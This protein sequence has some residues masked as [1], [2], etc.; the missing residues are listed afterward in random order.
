MELLYLSTFYLQYSMH[1]NK[2]Q[3]K[4]TVSE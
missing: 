1:N 3:Y 2:Q 4:K